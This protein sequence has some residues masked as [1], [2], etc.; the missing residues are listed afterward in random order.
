[1][2]VKRRKAALA[3]RH[4]EGYILER[5]SGEFATRRLQ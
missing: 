5:G 3:R 2:I 4:D 1:M